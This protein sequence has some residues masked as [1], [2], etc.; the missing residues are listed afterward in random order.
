MSK[1]FEPIGLYGL[2]KPILFSIPPERAHSLSLQ[3]LCLA[4]KFSWSR[5]LLRSICAPNN[6]PVSLFGMELSNRIGL[7]AGYD[8]NATSLDGL[9]AMGFGH[10]EIG[11]IVPK[12]QPG[13]PSPRVHRLPQESALV[14]R[15]GFPSEGLDLVSRRIEAYLNRREQ[16]SSEM[17]Q[18]PMLGINIG[19][20][21]VTP[22]EEAHRDYLECFLRLSDF[23]DYCTI[24]ISSPNTPNLRE[25]QNRTA[26]ESLLTP[27]LNARMKQ[28]K[29]TP[30][31]VKLSPD[32]SQEQRC[33]TLHQL[34]ELGVEG[35]VLSNT[36]RTLE[37]W[38]GGRSGAFLHDQTLG[39][40]REAKAETPSLRL[41]ASGGIGQDDDVALFT[42][43][44]ADLVQV[45]TALIYRGPR[46]LQ[47]L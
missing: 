18:R 5:A 13:N 1:R 40:I 12:P 31:L 24:N 32:L 34:V 3:A 20:N 9:E 47:K 36:K 39:L 25:L 11:T 10:I 2:S 43:A 46:L 22:N 14:N 8:K 35:V 30:L 6:D 4:G 45:W 44:G 37:P 28:R 21:K 33:Q 23:A 26:L 42:E 19:R 38:E 15:L 7:A 27:I 41:I 17:Q 29:Q 16:R